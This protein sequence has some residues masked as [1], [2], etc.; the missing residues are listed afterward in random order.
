MDRAAA[1]WPFIQAGPAASGIYLYG[2]RNLSAAATTHPPHQIQLALLFN[3]KWILPGTSW[4]TP[5]NTFNCQPK[6]KCCCC[7]RAGKPRTALNI[8]SSTGQLPREDRKRQNVTSPTTVYSCSSLLHW[9]HFWNSTLRHKR[10][11]NGCIGPGKFN[12]ERFD[13]DLYHRLWVVSPIRLDRCD[14]GENIS[15]K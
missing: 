9:C 8:K 12:I 14:S 1:P 3:A 5:F 11:L 15:T 10:G 13:G 7:E 6:R 2:T 4:N